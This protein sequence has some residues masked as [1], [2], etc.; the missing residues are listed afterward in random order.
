M[1]NANDGVWDAQK[2]IWVPKQDAPTAAPVVKDDS[3]N[4]PDEEVSDG[5]E[6]GDV[7]KFPWQ[8]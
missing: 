4:T 6:E 2:G 5:D 3:A 8:K 7:K 1:T